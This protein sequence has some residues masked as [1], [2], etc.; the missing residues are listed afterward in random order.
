M[1]EYLD[2]FIELFGGVAAD[3]AN[4]DAA[5]E[6][7][8]RPEQ[9]AVLRQL[10]SNA[11]MEQRRCLAFRDKCINRPLPHEEVRPLLNQISID[12]RDQ[13]LSFRDLNGAATHL[14]ELYGVAEE[15][16]D[17]RA[18]DRRSLFT[19]FLPKKD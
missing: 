17:D 8:A 5:L 4:V 2:G 1:L 12:T 9:A 11:S 7:G 13:L 18:F 16:K 10:A 6:D 14:D 3:L 19:R 15:P